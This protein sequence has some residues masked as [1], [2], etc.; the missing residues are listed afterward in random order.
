MDKPTL[1][2]EMLVL[3]PLRAGDS[4]GMWEVV[5]DA[6]ARRITGMSREW[7]RADVDRWVATVGAAD[8]RIDLAV[9]ANGSDEYLG[10][11]VLEAIDTC[12]GSASLRL[13]MRPAYRGRGYGTEAI[14]LV[15]GMAFDGLGLHRVGAAVPAINARAKS[16]YENLGFRVEGRLRDAFR[17]GDGWTDGL[18]MGLLDDE[19]RASQ[20]PAGTPEGA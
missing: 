10:E 3:R 15:L 7:T 12:V 20:L 8:D 19:Y 11:I 9:T 13:T 18:V 14:L 5:S 1:Q 2:G 6:E 17:D 16:L 4:D